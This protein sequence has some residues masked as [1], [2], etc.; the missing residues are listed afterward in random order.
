MANSLGPLGL[1]LNTQQELVDYFS[2]QFRLIYGSDINLEQSSPDGQ[3]MMIFVQAVLDV[4]DVLL[5][6]YN[7]FDP[8]LA[9]GRVLDQRVAI[10]GIQRQAGTYTI[11]NVTVTTTESTVTLYGLDQ[12]AN[13]IFTVEDD[14]GNKWNLITS[15][16][17]S[18]AGEHV[19]AFQSEVPGAVLTVP[20]TIRIPVTVVLGVSDIDNPTTYT[21]LGINE[22]SD[23]DLKIRRQKSVSLSSQGYLEGL[24][25]ALE[26]IPGLTFAQVYENT[27]G[28]TDGDGIPSHSIWVIVAGAAAVSAIANAIYTKR[29]AGCGMK[30]DQTFAITQADGSTFVVRWD[31]VETE[32]LF[33]KYTATSLDGVNPPNVEA[34]REGL[35]TSFV[36][37]VYEKVNI[38]DLATAVQVIDSNTLVTDAGFS[39]GVE[40]TLGFSGIAASGTFKVH[41]NG[42]DSAAINWNDNLATLEGKIQ[43]VTGLANVDVTGSIASQSLVVDF[44]LVDSILG[45]LTIKDNSL[46]TSAP[47]AIT[48]TN[49]PDYQTTLLPMAKNKQFS[50][51]SANIIIIPIVVNPPSDTANDGDVIDFEAAGG[52]GTYVWSL[53]SNI[54]GGSINSSTGVYTA[55]STPGT[56]VVRVT[57]AQGNFASANVVVS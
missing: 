48:I 30:G 32:T 20:G 44:A 41:Y 51:S 53:F 19:L 25:A 54:S 3:L 37:S 49:D 33:I 14:A 55:G 8:D 47:A 21:T 34:E 18:G 9:V 23:F 50:V 7:Q 6:V 13:Q 40:Q 2:A 52:Y 29:N 24:L 12:V 1:V 35:V 42:N 22:E 38:N 26:N 43:A 5:Q 4:Q 28:S 10:N 27:T 45:L 16:I 57:D 11:T 36:P 17:L 39:N 15:E 56:D 31:D 46:A